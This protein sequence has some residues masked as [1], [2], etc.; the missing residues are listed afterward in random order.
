MET[1]GTHRA[2][3]LWMMLAMAL[4]IAC[5]SA[6]STA[7]YIPENEYLLDKVEIKSNDKDFDPSQLEQYVRLRGNS[8][9]FSLFKIPLGI[10]AMSGRDSTKWVNR[11]LKRVGE[12][13]VLYDTV[14]AMVTQRDL[15]TALQ[16]MG[17]MNAKVNHSVKVKKKKLKAIYTLEPGRPF[18][19]RNMTYDIQDQNI[20]D[21]LAENDSANLVLHSGSP[22]TINGLD[23]ERSRIS[24]LL[25]DRG[26][27]KFHKEFIRFEA[28]TMRGSRL[29]DVT[30][31]I[32]KYQEHSQMPE[33]EH[34]RYTIANID[35]L[36]ADST[37]SHIRQSVLEGSTAIQVGEP[38]KA[39]AVQRTY[40]NFSR[41]SAIR[42]TNLRFTERE[43]EGMLDCHVNYGL[44]KP[45]TISFQPEG[46]NTAGDLGA[47][48]TLT[49]QN[50]NLF[51][52][53]ELLSVSLRGAFEAITG[54]EGY[55][56]EDYVEYGA[57]TKILFPRFVA[58]FLSKDF[59]R[60]VNASSELSFSY[61][62]QNRPEFHRRVVSA[63]WRYRWEKPRDKWTFKWDAID[64]NY[65]YMPW[66]SSTFKQQYLDS[67]SNRNA[68]L[69]YNYEDLFI[70]RTGFGLT[71]NNGLHAIK[72]NVE[73]GG[74]LLRLAAS[75]MDFNRNRDGQYV[76]FNIAFAQYVKGDFD[77][78]KVFHLDNQNSFV[79]HAGLGIAYPYGNSR[80][81]PFEKRYFSGGANS[82][83]GWRVRGLGPGS[84]KGSHGAID[85][86]NQ[87][88][89]MK[90]DLNM[91]YRAHLFWKLGVALFVDAGNIWTLRAYDEQPGGQFKFSEFWRQLA[92]GYGMGFRFNFDYFILRFDMGMKAV[93]PAYKEGD[94]H[95]PIAHPKLSRDFTFH[96]AVGLPF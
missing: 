12:A 40:N 44:N 32:L 37:T 6:C 64:L 34:P 18:V 58:P 93:N 62:L 78:T 95:Y 4:V 8:K 57:E 53:S 69:R 50:R 89:D 16:N 74:N 24:S 59:K 13:P 9:W 29:V 47:A 10:Y 3:S 92:V 96:F 14:Q 87:T 33:T 39:S 84:F 42:F 76:L 27:Y 41:L 79:V 15:L 20:L 68:I 51:H 49:Y 30:M 22:F 31:H 91:E 65:I 1:L 45:S 82:V 54:L 43:E 11:T 63:G 36:C 5:L 2:T 72:A 88:G 81:L 48:A 35:Y 23:R 71:Y 7:K 56:N 38:Y 90:L 70:I 28:D 25:L 61:N 21:I 66:I 67:V 77:Y 46:T 75:L 55:Q 83:R 26:F 86:I 19:I 52:G 60:E 85:F 73:L 94:E 80:V 17:Y